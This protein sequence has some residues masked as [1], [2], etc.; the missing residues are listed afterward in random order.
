M[1]LT[2][3]IRSFAN[4][5]EAVIVKLAKKA[6]IPTVTK[7]HL[8]DVLLER[9]G[10]MDLEGATVWHPRNVVFEFGFGEYMMDLFGKGHLIYVRNWSVVGRR[11]DP[12]KVRIRVVHGASR[13][14]NGLNEHRLAGRFVLLTVHMRFRVRLVFVHDASRLDV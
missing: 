13:T 14:D 2:V 11:R 6:R 4:V 7:V 1:E 5:F 8:T 12:R 9:S 10:T 3:S